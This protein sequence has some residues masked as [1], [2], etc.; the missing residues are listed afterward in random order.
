MSKQS[1]RPGRRNRPGRQRVRVESTAGQL[2]IVIATSPQSA[3]GNVTLAG[4]TRL[5]RAAL[6]Y[7]DTVELVSPAV[8]MVG[9]VAALGDIGPGVVEILAELDDD[10]LRSRGLDPD[11]LRAGLGLT[12]LSRKDRRRAFGAAAAREVRQRYTAMIDGQ[13]P[14]LDD[15]VN[16]IHGAA[17]AEELEL[18]LERGVLT[19]ATPGPSNSLD[20]DEY[21]ETLK[22]LVS[23]PSSHLLFD[24]Q[25]S[26]LVSA[27]IREG[28]VEPHRLTMTRTGQAV[29]GAG[30]VQRLPAFPDTTMAA[31][32]E[33]RDQ[34]IDPLKTYRTATV[35][36]ASKLAAGPF[37]DDIQPE[38]DD[39][40][41]NAVEPAVEKIR[42]DL[43]KTRLARDALADAVSDVT[44]W[45]A[46]GAATFLTM[47]VADLAPIPGVLTAAAIT[48]AG[49]ATKNRIAAKDGARTEQL[50]YLYEL[51]RR[52]P[53]T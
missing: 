50:Y 39:L 6:L 49:T 47:G 25:I 38:L 34:L 3:D 19:L 53:R 32:L 10:T 40:W 41:R 21:A 29:T 33:A 22:R 45:V 42:K 46:T 1:G 36:L 24:E 26:G 35:E 2:K 14:E 12:H 18:A 11:E 4:D 16:D 44:S 20:M 15:V 5:V 52:L 13:R 23:S 48:A 37:D 31:V 8:W 51:G 28:A 17:G 43:A 27:M 30:M 7:A 9:S